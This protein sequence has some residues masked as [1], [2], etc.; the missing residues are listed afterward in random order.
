[1][2]DLRQTGRTTRML[3]HAVRRTHK[4][5]ST[6]IVTHERNYAGDLDRRLGS[7]LPLKQSGVPWNK[8]LTIISIQDMV[9]RS[10]PELYGYDYAQGLFYQPVPDM[11]Q[12]V[13]FDHA[14]L[15]DHLFTVQNWIE[16]STTI[17]DHVRWLGHTARMMASL[18]RRTYVITDDELTSS[19]VTEMTAG[20]NVM[21]EDG[22]KM[23][24]L[25]WIN[26]TLVKA[27][28]NH[29]VL[30]EPKMLQRR[31]EGA[32]EELHRWDEDTKR[33]DGKPE[34]QFM[35][36]EHVKVQGWTGFNTGIITGIE[37]IFHHRLGEHT[38][39]YMIDLDEGQKPCLTFIY[40]PEGYLSELG[41]EEC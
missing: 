34:Q 5:L 37:W 19:V 3:N 40:V 6:V 4:G 7:M 2:K 1:M 14:A 41:E 33:K 23:S 13:L 31:F 17:P 22:S 20:Y 32:L 29:M 25:D 16:A 15:E 36:G 18:G 27:H 21:V 30:V 9:S 12:E 8:L 35:I 11:R 38:W 26:L 39:G 24:N 10:R 28:P